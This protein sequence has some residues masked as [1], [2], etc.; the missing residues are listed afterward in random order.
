MLRLILFAT[1]TIST[2]VPAVASEV[3]SDKVSGYFKYCYYADGGVLTV[4]NNNQC[5]I[6]NRGLE[7]QID[8]QDTYPPGTFAG[9]EIIGRYKYCHYYGGASNPIPH[10]DKCPPT[11]N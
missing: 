10:S 9:E 4:G 2:T 3:V 6:T 8:V 1:I 11:N 7:G 5:P